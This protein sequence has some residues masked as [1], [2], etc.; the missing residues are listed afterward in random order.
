MNHICSVF[1]GGVA[2][3]VLITDICIFLSY[4]Y[5]CIIYGEGT[6]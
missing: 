6:T 1:H 3:H 2:I 4:M 5:K